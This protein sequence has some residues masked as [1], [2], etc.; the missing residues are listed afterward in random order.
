MLRRAVG[1]RRGA[2]W[3]PPPTSAVDSDMVIVGTVHARSAR[4]TGTPDSR[5]R[6]RRR[7]P[8]ESTPDSSSRGRNIP[9][10][11]GDGVIAEEASCLSAD[12]CRGCTD[13]LR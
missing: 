8:R 11:P 5:L 13:A 6:P 2:S 1:G 12:F 9:N 4:S 3:H 7:N 10:E